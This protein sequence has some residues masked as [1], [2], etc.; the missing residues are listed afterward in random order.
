MSEILEIR[1]INR[2]PY[3][4]KPV[5]N[6]LVTHK[7]FPHGYPAVCH[8]AVYPRQD[9]PPMII[10]TEPPENRG[11]SVTNA[12]EYLATAIFNHPRFRQVL[13]EDPR[14]C[15]WIEHYP[16]T[17]VREET[18]DMVYLA[19]RQENGEWTAVGEE[20]RWYHLDY[21]DLPKPRTP[22]VSPESF[23]A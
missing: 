13:G 1:E 2:I 18:W 15:L 19:W 8:A 16:E 4:G 3:E 11:M 7:P 20:P 5:L 23:F 21:H 22:D 17:D 12:I 6:V 14:D 10:L 9:R